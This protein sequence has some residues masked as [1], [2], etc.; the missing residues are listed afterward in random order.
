MKVKPIT[1]CFLHLPHTHYPAAIFSYHREQ[2]G[3][4]GAPIVTT[5][6]CGCVCVCVCVNWLNQHLPVALHQPLFHPRFCSAPSCCF[7]FG[8]RAKSS[9]RSCNGWLVMPVMHRQWYKKQSCFAWLLALRE[10]NAKNR[11]GVGSFVCVFLFFLCKT[12]VATQWPQWP[13]ME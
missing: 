9:S 2:S 10:N 11:L 6:F 12:C 1:S 13:M 4:S 7:S 3:G 5:F 8:C